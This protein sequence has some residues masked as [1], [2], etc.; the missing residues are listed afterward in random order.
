MECNVRFIDTITEPGQL[1]HIY[2]R[3]DEFDEHIVKEPKFLSDVEIELFK[4]IYLMNRS[5]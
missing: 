5:N 4:F 2:V 1:I 3:R